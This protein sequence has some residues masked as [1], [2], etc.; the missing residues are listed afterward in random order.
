MR[1][2]FYRFVGIALICT[3]VTGCQSVSGLGS[4]PPLESAAAPDGGYRLGAGDHV[5][6]VVFGAQELS[7]TDLSVAADGT[8]ALPLAGPVKAEGRS[9]TELTE[10]VRAKLLDGYVH[11]PKVSMQVLSYRPF[12][13]LGEVKTPGE[14]PYIPGMTATTAVARA[15]GFTFRAYEDAFSVTRNGAKYRATDMSKLQPDDVMVVPA[16]VF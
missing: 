4:L 1:S 10:A 5:S 9:L 3:A 11:D 16:R 8:I 13:I 15:G 2:F 14:Y 12:Y 6:L 7:A